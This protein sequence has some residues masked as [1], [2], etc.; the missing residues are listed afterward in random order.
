MQKNISS[1]IIPLY[2]LLTIA[3]SAID[4]PLSQ[5]GFESLISYLCHFWYWCG[6]GRVRCW[7][8]AGELSTGGLGHG[9]V[10]D[11]VSESYSTSILM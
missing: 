5:I 10:R 7:V 4:N 1:P 11:C 2:V 6:M 9:T 3:T 8:S